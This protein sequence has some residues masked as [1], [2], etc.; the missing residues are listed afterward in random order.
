MLTEFWGAPIHPHAVLTWLIILL[1]VLV[2]S[3]TGLSISAISTNGKVK[4]GEFRGH[5]YLDPMLSELPS[6]PLGYP[7]MS[8]LL[9]MGTCGGSLPLKVVAAA[10]P[11]ALGPTPLAVHCFFSRPLLC[12]R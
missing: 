7:I 6:P 2:T 1:S 12:F 8:A 5:L 11:V 3:I 9:Q 10:H 4:S